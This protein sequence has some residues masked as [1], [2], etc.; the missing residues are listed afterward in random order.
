MLKQIITFI[1]N[2]KNEI[3][4]EVE[5]DAWI[6]NSPTKQEINSILSLIQ[7]ERTKQENYRKEII[8]I[9]KEL[10][11]DHEEF[12]DE[13]LKSHIED[14][15][16]SKN[17][18]F[19]FMLSCEEKI[20]K[21]QSALKEFGHFSQFN[22]KKLTSEVSDFDLW[23]MKNDEKSRLRKLVEESTEILKALKNKS[24]YD[25][26]NAAIK[27]YEDK[28]G[29]NFDKYLDIKDELE[30]YEYEEKSEQ[31]RKGKTGVYWPI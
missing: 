23:R 22:T 25:E 12:S 11:V 5:E 29:I 3:D 30:D 14:L 17:L 27:F 4:V 31:I 26:N 8:N 16:Q 21:Y 6:E 18:K 1:K 10:R 19:S 2:W 7:D 28:I 24:S 20:I 15:H 9:R 13:K